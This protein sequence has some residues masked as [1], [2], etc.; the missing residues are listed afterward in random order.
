MKNGQK[1][2]LTGCYYDSMYLIWLNFNDLEHF[3]QRLVV[4]GNHKPG[5]SHLSLQNLK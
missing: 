2:H 3:R 4:Q 5:I 1:I